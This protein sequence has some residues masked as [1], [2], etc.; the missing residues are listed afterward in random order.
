[1]KSSVAERPQLVLASASPRR[2]DLL[3]Q[4]GVVPDAVDPADIDETPL[5]GE[6]PRRTAN[7]LATTKADLVAARR[8][9]AFVL[10]ADTVVAVGRRVLGKPADELEAR[11]MLEL[12]SGRNHR[13]Y[14]GVAV[15]APGGRTA[16]RVSEARVTFKRLPA[17]DTGALIDCGEWRGVAGGYRI[18]GRAGAVVTQLVGSYSAVVGLPLYETMTL[19]GG[20]GYV[21]A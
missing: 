19:L 17:H 6:T 10:A 2:L 4:I 20:L 21:S 12:L 14:T 8:P 15:I 18:Q 16:S 5:A 3:G 9:G 11:A 7:R 13:V 1:V